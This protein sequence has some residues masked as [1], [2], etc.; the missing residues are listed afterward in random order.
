M[1]SANGSLFGGLA[2]QN[3][4]IRDERDVTDYWTVGGLARA[5]W[6]GPGLGGQVD[7]WG[8]FYD[9]YRFP[10]AGPL[11]DIPSTSRFGVAVHVTKRPTMDTL[12]G[13]FVSL[14]RRSDSKPL[15]A[16]AG[17]EAQ[18]TRGQLV[19]GG[20][21]GY[22]RPATDSYGTSPRAGAFW[23][24]SS[25]TYFPTPNLSLDLNGSIAYSPNYNGG[26][27]FYPDIEGSWYRWGSKIE[28]RPEGRDYSFFGEYRGALVRISGQNEPLGSG[29][30]NFFETTLLAGVRF[31]R[32]EPSLYDSA[33]HGASLADHNPLYGVDFTIQ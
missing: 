3:F 18:A 32:N 14:G 25:A 1:S 24:Y 7:F 20:Q 15:L 16:A 10:L 26:F 5:A 23:L 22:A 19:L 31:F 27:S 8:Q 13:A 33:V 12:L 6:S 17:L 9:P 28:Y 30:D 21:V 2:R 11:Y 4:P 29:F